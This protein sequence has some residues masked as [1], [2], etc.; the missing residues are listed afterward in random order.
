MS[1]IYITNP[2][3]EAIAAI[4]AA[5]H[6]V[7]LEMGDGGNNHTVTYIIIGVRH[8]QEAGYVNK[9]R[10]KHTS[11]Y[12]GRFSQF[13]GMSPDCGDDLCHGI[14]G[15]I[16]PFLSVIAENIES[17]RKAANTNPAWPTKMAQV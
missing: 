3:F 7:E 13:S 6:G 5:G 8:P 11:S 17:W 2:I 4:H 10:V 1:R 16:T 9:L 15:V 14:T 12:Q